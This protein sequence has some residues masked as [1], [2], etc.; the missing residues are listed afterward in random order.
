MPKV[1]YKLAD[2][3]TREVEVPVGC[4]V[5]FGA[6]TQDVPGI[7]AD[8]GGSLS[9]ATCHVYVDAAWAQRLAPPQAMENDLLENTAA[10]RR[11][12][13]RLSCQIVMTP[14]IDGIVVEI[15][16]RQF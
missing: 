3:Q 5:M 15:P 16:E 10:E 4:S 8:C 7:A 6:T 1:L 9:C 13:S 2:G 12:N 11:S 14:E